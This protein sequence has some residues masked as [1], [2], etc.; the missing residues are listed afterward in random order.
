[1]GTVSRSRTK[2][3]KQAC[4]FSDGVLADSVSLGS[5]STIGILSWTSERLENS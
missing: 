1:M 5:Q 4:E 2:K 3:R